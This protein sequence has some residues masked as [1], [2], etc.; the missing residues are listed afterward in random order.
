MEQRTAKR[1]GRSLAHNIL[2]EM[3]MLALE[4]MNE[5]VHPDA[6]SASFGMHRGARNPLRKGE[7][8][9]PKVREQL[10]QVQQNPEF[11]RTFFR[12]PSVQASHGKDTG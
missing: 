12:H 9:G 8:L 3:R 10:T 7:K 1:D 4:R 5:G 11:V 2:E 6:V